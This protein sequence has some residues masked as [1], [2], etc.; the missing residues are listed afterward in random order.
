VQLPL[1]TNACLFGDCSAAVRTGN[2][3]T[4]DPCNLLPGKL[5]RRLAA[6]CMAVTVHSTAEQNV[7][8]A[9][10][11]QHHDAR[12]VRAYLRAAFM[13]SKASMRHPV[14]PHHN[15]P[16]H[17]GADL[18]TGHLLGRLWRP[19]HQLQGE[20]GTAQAASVAS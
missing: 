11:A 18:R 2:I 3:H 15:T 17:R 20:G 14:T 1:E 8:A 10:A 7:A 9:A 6:R 5:D 19:Y 4:S 12:V 13:T 16:H